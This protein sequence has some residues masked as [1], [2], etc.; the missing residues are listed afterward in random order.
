MQ[1]PALGYRPGAAKVVLVTRLTDAAPAPL[2]VH[3]R[4]DFKTRSVTLA[5]GADFAVQLTLA[6]ARELAL[7]LRR[8]ANH[9]ERTARKEA[10]TP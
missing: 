7:Q 10:S 2:Q 9:I 5:F 4:P 3:L 8:A 1:S 6:D